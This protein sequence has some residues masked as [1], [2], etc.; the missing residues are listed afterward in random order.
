MFRCNLPLALLA[1]W[2]GSFMCHC[3]NTWVE[4]TH[5]S[6]Q[7][8]LTLEMKILSLLL[9]GFKLATFRTWVWHSNQQVI[10]AIFMP[11]VSSCLVSKAVWWNYQVQSFCTHLQYW[12]QA[13]D[14]SIKRYVLNKKKAP[15][16]FFFLFF[17]FFFFSVWVVVV[18]LRHA[19]T[20]Y[21]VI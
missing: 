16:F 15:L 20:E 6:Q 4:Q 17:F 9:P 2:P 3:G 12:V 5:E 1:E 18:V 10:P 21:N 19:A 7:T 8:K 13:L 11:C 14:M